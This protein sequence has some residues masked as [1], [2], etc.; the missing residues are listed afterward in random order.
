M[1]LR[2]QSTDILRAQLPAEGQGSPVLRPALYR[3]LMEFANNRV[4]ISNE[5]EAMKFCYMQRW[6]GSLELKI[7]HSGEQ[8]RLNCPFC[9]DTRRR[10]YINHRWGYYDPITHSSNLHLA[11]CHNE[12]CMQETGRYT[13]LHSMVYSDFMHE[14]N[15]ELLD[16]NRAQTVDVIARWPGQLRAINQMPLGLDACQYLL[17]R[18]YDLDELANT[19]NV[20]YCLEADSCYPRAR[21]RIIIPIYTAGELKGWQARYVGI[22]PSKDVPKYVS[23]TGM[24]KTRLLYN[25]DVA[26]KYPYVVLCE[27]PTD[28]WRFG[29][30]AVAL[31]GKSISNYQLG[32]ITQ[33]WKKVYIALDGDAPEE[34]QII[35]D[36]LSNKV[37]EKVVV[38]FPP[39]VDPGDLPRATLRDM[40]FNPSPIVIAG[41]K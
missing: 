28:V 34:A 1:P 30:E 9:T 19:F 5:G 38:N 40:V 29:P 20:T 2:Q 32:V 27:G 18:G 7:E 11:Y 4:S 13:T 10:L 15:D 26:R 3:R 14:A 6:D 24:K 33:L 37:E 16:G 23:M 35:Y 12:K 25:M 8:Y 22:P 36:E 21:G 31:F 39:K 17:Q 41:G